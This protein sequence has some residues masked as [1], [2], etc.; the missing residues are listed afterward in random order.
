MRPERCLNC[1]LHQRRLDRGEGVRDFI[2]IIGLTGD[3]AVNYPGSLCSLSQTAFRPRAS[4]G[5][6]PPTF[7][8][9][10]AS[11]PEEVPR[12]PGRFSQWGELTVDARDVPKLL[13]RLQPAFGP[14]PEAGPIGDGGAPGSHREGVRRRTCLHDPIRA[15]VP[16]ARHRIFSVRTDPRRHG[17]PP[18]VSQ[19]RT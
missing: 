10:L 17:R 15:L 3:A 9:W 12:R 11:S 4:F 1:L 16:G 18:S 6:Q 14:Q 13:E 7:A 5:F 2:E 19:T 8:S